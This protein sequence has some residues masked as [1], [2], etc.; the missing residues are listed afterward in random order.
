VCCVCVCVSVLLVTI[1]TLKILGTGRWSIIS[2]QVFN[3]SEPVYDYSKARGWLDMVPADQRIGVSGNDLD[4]HSWP[5]DV[6]LLYVIRFYLFVERCDQI[7]GVTGVL[8]PGAHKIYYG[9]V[10]GKL[11]NFVSLNTALLAVHTCTEKAS[12]A[13]EIARVAEAQPRQ[14]HEEEKGGGEEEV[15][16]VD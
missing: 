11:I 13:A 9:A 2:L 15:V 6:G 1:K 10:R 4:N 3:G 5:L 8:H 12:A 16:V 14:R 7:Q